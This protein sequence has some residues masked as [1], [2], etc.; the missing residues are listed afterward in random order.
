MARRADG[1]LPEPERVALAVPVGDL[2]CTR[3]FLLGAASDGSGPT[4][5]RA[6]SS[7]SAAS[8]P[9][10]WSYGRRPD[11]RC[12]PRRLSFGRAR[13][14]F[15]RPALRFR[16]PAPRRA[17]SGPSAPVIFRLP[18][19]L[20]LWASLIDWAGLLVAATAALV[21]FSACRQKELRPAGAGGV[22]PCP[23]ARRLGCLHLGLQISP[24]APWRALMAVFTILPHGIRC[25]AAA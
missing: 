11:E 8:L 16:G 25:R 21:G 6:S 19:G 17:P 2:S 3:R 5:V 9:H 13:R 18:V 4:L 14:Y 1:Q 24:H 7:A 20:S 23:A 10:G 15:A 12:R 22:W